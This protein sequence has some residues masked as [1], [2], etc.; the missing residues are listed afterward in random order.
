MANSIFHILLKHEDFIPNLLSFFRNNNIDSFKSY[1]YL[2]TIFTVTL[3]D[4]QVLLLKKEKYIKNIEPDQKGFTASD[5]II[6][7]INGNLGLDRIDQRSLPLNGLFKNIRLGS[8]ANIYLFDTG[9][10]SDHSELY[11]RVTTLF[12]AFVSESN[13]NYGQDFDGHGTWVASIIGGTSLGVAPKSNLYSVKIANPGTTV[14]IIL[15][16]IDQVINYHTNLPSFPSPSFRL[17]IANFSISLPKNNILENAILSLPNYGIIPVIAAGNQSSLAETYSPAGS[18]VIVNDGSYSFATNKPIVV[19]SSTFNDE[20]SSFS[21]YGPAITI[22]AP[23]NDIT[24]SDIKNQHDL[25]TRSGT[26]ASAALVSGAIACYADENVEADLTDVLD[27]L[28]NNATLDTIK[29]NTISGFPLNANP[30]IDVNNTPNKLLFL[31]FQSANIIWQTPDGLLGNVIEGNSAEFTIKA[32]DELSRPVTYHLIDGVIPL[33]FDSSTGIIS[34]V[35]IN[36]NNT[37]NFRFTIRATAGS[38]FV[39]RNFSITVNNKN[40]KPSWITAS[41]SLGTFQENEIVNIQLSVTDDDTIVYSLQN[42]SLPPGLSV[43]STGL[44]SGTATSPGLNEV[45]NFTIRASDGVYKVDRSFSIMVKNIPNQPYFVTTSNLGTYVQG[46]SVNI[47]IDALDIDHEALEYKMTYGH[48]ATATAI[49]DTDAKIITSVLI[50]SPGQNYITAPNVYF[51]SGGGATAIP[52]ITSGEITNVNITN[53]G[54]DYRVPPTVTITGDGTGASFEAQLHQNQISNI[55][56]LNKGS[57]YTTATLNISTGITNAT[58]TSSILSGEVSNITITSNGANYTKLP[59]II[60]TPGTFTVGSTNSITETLPLGLS[61]DSNGLITGTIDVN[62]PVGI[63]TFNVTA[64]DGTSA[65]ISQNFSIIVKPFDSDIIN[66]KIEWETDSG[67]LGSMYEFYPSPFYVSAI[68]SNSLKVNYSM[69]PG[70][71]SLPPGLFL[72]PDNGNITGRATSVSV[73][74]LYTFSLRA[75]IAER[76]SIYVDRE[77]SI[78]VRNRFNSDI[79]FVYSKITG[80]FKF[81]IS[82]WLSNYLPGQILYKSG[83]LYFGLQSDIKMLIAGGITPSTQTQFYE[84]IKELE[85]SPPDVGNEPY[86]TYHKKT[87][88]YLGDLGL[89]KVNNDF[90][91]PQYEVLYINI[92]DPSSITRNGIVYTAGGFVEGSEQLLPYPQQL[93]TNTNIQHVFSNTFENMRQDLINDL[94]LA[95][96]EYIPIWQLQNRNKWIPAIELAYLKPGEGEKIFS[97]LKALYDSQFK[98]RE[99]IL[100]CYFYVTLSFLDTFFDDDDTTFDFD[101]TTFDTGFKENGKYYKF[102]K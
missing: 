58:A 42:G 56:I 20:Y 23:G 70:S 63:Y 19:G 93:T 50:T 34:G 3:T 51:Y 35:A 98:N 79:S 11:P 37:T 66:L 32:Y 27:F 33:N 102:V 71:G 26:S 64:N 77:F 17:G 73:D 40:Q 30:L 16:A 38:N 84:C 22:I 46:Q 55:S 80:P 100:D 9:I 86:A 69:V 92:V 28:N 87:K 62:A 44:I 21:N 2:N 81:E 94:G 95:G 76:P 97:T 57:G 61:L 67:T 82:D 75:F 59:T 52:I 14:S 43:S 7:N 101:T 89:L 96:N 24:G 15:N 60:I 39:D 5:R 41:G 90:G 85:Y 4:T 78:Y 29:F 1:K 10:K 49:L 65:S 47:K 54:F 53:T 83:D 25:Q 31:P 45:Y 6:T 99:F 88:I 74:T 36:V 91:Q 18:G 72:N 12:D 13:T 48:G 8:K 68:A